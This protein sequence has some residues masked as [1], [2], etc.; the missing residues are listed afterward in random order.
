[1]ADRQRTLHGGGFGQLIWRP[2]SLV[3]PALAFLAVFYLLPLAALALISV[4]AP[5]YSP[6]NY[7]D[8]FQSPSNSRVLVRTLGVGVSVT[9][10]CVI[11]G[12]PTA[13]ALCRAGKYRRLLLLLVIVP[14]LTSFLVRTYAWIVLLGRKGIIN[15]VLLASG[16]IDRPLDLIYNSFAVHVGMVHVM[17]PLAILPMYSVMRGIDPQLLMA[18]KSLGSGPLRSHLRVFL[19]L[20]VPGVLSGALLVFLLC[21]G[22]YITPILLGGLR[23]VMLAAFIDAQVSQ[24]GN[25]G[26]AAA[27]AFILLCVTL[28]GYFGV[29][30]VTGLKLGRPLQSSVADARPR[31]NTLAAL[32]GKGFRLTADLLNKIRRGAG[33]TADSSMRQLPALDKQRFIADAMARWFV[34]IW[35]GAV[36][37]YLILPIFVVVPLSFSSSPHLQ[38]PPPGFS[39]RWY[40]GYFGNPAWLNPTLLS[41]EVAVACTVLSTTLGTFAAYGLV[42]GRLRASGLLTGLLISPMIVPAIVL[43]VALYSRFAAWGMIGSFLSLTISH[44]IGALPYVVIIVSATLAGFDASLERASLTLGAGPARTFAKITVPLIKAGIISAALLAFI[45]SFDELVI[46]MFVAGARVQTLPLKMWE[47]IRAEIDPTIAAVSCLLIL[48]PVVLLGLNWS[49]Q[50]WRN[51]FAPAWGPGRLIGPTTMFR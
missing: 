41:I 20:T 38:F 2:G 31:I 24:L 36:L 9:V 45:H 43:G 17:L 47:N 34:R 5:A 3:V 29:C 39:M 32:I 42:R 44:A 51:R 22:F 40:A 11:L 21:L 49:A 13:Y 35:A 48:L 27:A 12:Y 18:A 28:L 19:P 23:D 10:A 25:W 30:W 50:R 14:Y 7:V 37:L 33:A 4:N 1:L 8:F 26:F 15:S 16:L 46:S 6:A